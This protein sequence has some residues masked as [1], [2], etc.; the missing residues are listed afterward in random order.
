[1]TEWQGPFAGMQE[2]LEACASVGVLA[3]VV[4]AVAAWVLRRRSVQQREL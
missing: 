4:A 3:G 2:L 1:M